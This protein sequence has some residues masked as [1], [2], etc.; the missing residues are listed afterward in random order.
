MPKITVIE[1]YDLDHLLDTLSDLTIYKLRVHMDE[2]T[3]E[4]SFKVNERAWTY[5]MGER[6]ARP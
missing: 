4:V 5:P 6:E 1:D 3:G 2:E